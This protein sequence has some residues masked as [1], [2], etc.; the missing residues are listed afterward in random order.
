M[1][2][3]ESVY[4]FNKIK[5]DI[6]VFDKK[7]EVDVDLG[8]CNLHWVEEL[9]IPKFNSLSFKY[10]IIE[11]S[12]ALKPWLALKL[13]KK[14][15]KVIFL[16]P[17]VMVFNHLESVFDD[18]EH[19]PVIITPHYFFPKENGMIDDEK[20]MRFGSYNLGFFAVNCSPESKKFLCWWSARCLS[21]GFDDAQFGIFTDQKWVSIAQCFFPF[22]HVSY[23]P[24]LNVAFWNLDERTISIDIDGQYLVNKEYHLLF[25]HFS[26][27]DNNHPENLSKRDFDMG[28]NNN[29]IISELGLIYS[30]RLN[31]NNNIS[32]DT[33]YSFDYM[34]DGRYISPSFRRAY[35]AHLNDFPANHNPF[36]GY[37]LVADY[38]KK[39]HLYQKNNKNYSVQGYNS[40]D[41]HT[42]KLKIVYYL[43]RCAL[44]ILGPNNFMNLSRLLVYLSSYHRNQNIWKFKKN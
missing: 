10:T 37:G 9:E 21:N 23:N 29:S 7:R 12:T 43:M 27:F 11:L 5:T 17:D 15:P 3:A 13:L 34:S 4:K 32:D 30:E 18:L 40:I 31:Q 38:A 2:L 19:Y 33:T 1:V 16:D 44:K 20:I 42:I 8:V 14:Y 28:S 41:N 26:S 36:D 35:A 24:G 39:N 6:F 22:L 25:F